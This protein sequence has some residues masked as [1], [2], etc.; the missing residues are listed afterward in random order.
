[1]DE[2][3]IST[4]TSE[5]RRVAISLLDDLASSSSAIDT[6]LMRAKRL[7]RLMRDTDAQH[8]LDLETSGYPA[9]FSSIS[10]GTCRK[11][12]AACGR[13]NEAESKFYT[14][15]LP[16]LE[17]NAESE[18]LLMAAH[19]PSSPSQSKVKDFIEKNATEA[20]MATQLKL[21]A[22]QKKNYAVSKSIFASLKASIHN[23]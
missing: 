12:A 21:Q 7:A 10:L 1:M 3:T 8:W 22:V 13:L 14:Q 5:A 4:R 17:A 19:K 11:Y 20:L 15:S 16:E 9:S 18:Q 6:I 23:L 2:K